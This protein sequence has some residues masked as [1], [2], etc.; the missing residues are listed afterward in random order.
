[1]A[2][3]A[4]AN[5]IV[6]PS[7]ATISPSY[8]LTYDCSEVRFFNK[9]EVAPYRISANINRRGYGDREEY[10]QIPFP[11]AAHKSPQLKS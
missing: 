7:K 3:P 1:V 2:H 9:R 8:R 10:Q 11:I 4:N 6:C 5:R